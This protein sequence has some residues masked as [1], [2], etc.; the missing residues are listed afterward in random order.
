VPQNLKF[1][2]GGLGKFHFSIYLE[3]EARE[4]R[5][6][7]W[8]FHF[9]LESFGAGVL[10]PTMHTI[11]HFACAFSIKYPESIETRASRFMNATTTRFTLFRSR[12]R[13]L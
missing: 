5:G 9:S 6:S 8:N 7:T 12:H 13:F 1:I 4:G 2:R 3:T 11:V 10:H